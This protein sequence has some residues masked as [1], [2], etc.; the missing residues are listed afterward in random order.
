MRN[1]RMP[2]AKGNCEAGNHIH[3][4]LYWKMV[5]ESLMPIKKRPSTHSKWSLSLSPIAKNIWPIAQHKEILSNSDL[6]VNRSMTMART[7]GGTRDAKNLIEKYMLNCASEM[8][9]CF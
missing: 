6:R 8:P 9:M 1:K 2:K 4:R 7:S 5:R 3:I